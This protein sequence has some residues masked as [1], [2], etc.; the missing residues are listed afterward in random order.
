[1][2]VKKGFIIIITLIIMIISL[3]IYKSI[4]QK[5]TYKKAELVAQ[6]YRN[7]I[8]RFPV[9]IK[10]G[11]YITF[12]TFNYYNIFEES[13]ESFNNGL[14]EIVL[15][16]ISTKYS[17]YIVTR[18]TTYLKVNINDEV[19]FVEYKLPIDKD[20]IKNLRTFLEDVGG[21][22]INVFHFNDGTTYV[23]DKYG[24]LID[25]KEPHSKFLIENKGVIQTLL[26]ILILI[27]L[28]RIVNFNISD[29]YEKRFINIMITIIEIPLIIL[30][31]IGILFFIAFM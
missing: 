27:V 9:D 22:A 10:S 31:L 25:T 20:Y 7:N 1:M 17:E 13:L 18:E 23:F 29:K 21:W 24:E 3:N 8:M 2:R 6:E 11:T 28:R 12:D 26:G 30:L 5:N 14:K 16:D 4:N 19:I 15:E